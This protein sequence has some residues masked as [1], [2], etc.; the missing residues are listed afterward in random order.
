[1]GKKGTFN[2][3]SS[4]TVNP[5]S[6]DIVVADTRIQIFS[7]KGDFLEVFYDEGKGI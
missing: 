7:G 5:I 4:V 2:L 6:G 3:I 1:M